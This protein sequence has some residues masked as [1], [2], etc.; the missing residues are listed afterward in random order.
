MGIIGFRRSQKPSSSRAK[1][2]D[3]LEEFNVKECFL[4]FNL[5]CW[6]VDESIAYFVTD[7]KLDI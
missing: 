1:G 2:Q 7:Y 5:T 6:T 3:D 4:N